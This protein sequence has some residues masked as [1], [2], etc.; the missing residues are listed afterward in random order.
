MELCDLKGN[1]VAISVSAGILNGKYGVGDYVAYS[2]WRY[3]TVREE[4]GK[5]IVERIS[6]G[7]VVINIKTGEYKIV[8]VD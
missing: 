4:D 1:N 6:D 7:Y 8:G 2:V 3:K 5:N